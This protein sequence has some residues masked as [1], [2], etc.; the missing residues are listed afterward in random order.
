MTKL[1]V[2]GEDGRIQDRFRDG[3]VVEADQSAMEGELFHTIIE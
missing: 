3:V 2:N 1:P